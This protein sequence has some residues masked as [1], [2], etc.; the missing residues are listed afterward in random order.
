MRATI[1]FSHPDKKFAILTKLLNIIKGIKNLRQHILADGILLERL[2]T[3]D[4]EKLKTALA[5]PN[6]SKCVISDNSVRVIIIG[7]ELRALFGLV[8]PIPG[9]QDD[10]A[11]IFWERGF[12]LEHLTPG[13]AEAIRNQLDT[14]A[15]VT[16]TPDTPQTR[17]Y[18]VSGQVSQDDGTPLSARGFT[19]RA[20][21]SLSGNGLVL[22]GS[23]ATLQADGSYRIDYA[24]RSNGR[25]GPDLLVRVFDAEGNVVAETKK[26]SAAIQEFLDMTAEGLCIV[27]GIIRYADGTPLP[28]VVVRA[29]DR[30][31]RAEALLGNTVADAEGFYEITYS[32]GQFQAKKAQA[33]L[34]MR[35]FR[36]GEEEEE[37][38]VSDIVFD[39][40]LQQAIDVEIESRKFPGP[41]EY[42]QYLTALKPFIVGEPIHELTDEDLSFLNGK[43]NIPLEHLNHLRVDAQWSFQYGLEPGVAY[44]LFRQG[45]PANLRRLLAEKPSGL[46]EALRVSLAHNVAPAPLAGQIDKV[47]ERLLSLADSPVVELDRKVK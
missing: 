16:I 38:A 42:E 18:T 6:Y 24:W 34:V 15:A 35:V 11:R 43:T 4:I 3:S 19:V 31:M 37:I 32:V 41:S 20:F 1:Q 2:D 26:S 45:L 21:D 10:F 30:D 22:C 13:Q 33:D 39:A 28:D 47:I 25:K 14:I 46:Y 5:G 23:T 12:T 17:I 44:G 36:Q 8:I 7:G 40:S 9:R 29:F 27:R